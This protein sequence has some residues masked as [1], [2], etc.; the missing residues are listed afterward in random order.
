MRAIKFSVSALG[1]VSLDVQG[2]VGTSCKDLTKPY[3]DALGGEA[4][5]IEKPEMQQVDLGRNSEQQGA[6]TAGF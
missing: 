1:K 3:E 6:F 2:A 4:T 5:V